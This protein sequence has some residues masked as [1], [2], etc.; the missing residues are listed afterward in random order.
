L[1][2][3]GLDDVGRNRSIAAQYITNALLVLLLVLGDTA[4]SKLAGEPLSAG[5]AFTSSVV[6]A[7]LAR[8][9]L[10][11]VY[12]EGGPFAAFGAAAGFFVSPAGAYVVM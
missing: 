12:E 5:P 9:L 8:T 2:T 1:A 10:P 3:G 4:S 7:E 11:S 6:L